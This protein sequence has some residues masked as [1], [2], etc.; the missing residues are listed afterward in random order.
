MLAVCSVRWLVGFVVGSVLL[1]L[2][3]VGSVLLV[4]G[5]WL[6]GWLCWLLFVPVVGVAV[7]FASDTSWHAFVQRLLVLLPVNSLE[8]LTHA[9]RRALEC[10][11]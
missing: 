7:V 2:V 5:C 6:R 11:A 4:V 10:C 1:L 8:A 9:G 3:V